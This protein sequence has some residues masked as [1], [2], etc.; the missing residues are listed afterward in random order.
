MSRPRYFNEYSCKMQEGVSSDTGRFLSWPKISGMFFGRG[1]LPHI[2]AHAQT[3]GN[4][5]IFFN[6]VGYCWPFTRRS[7]GQA[8]SGVIFI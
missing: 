1:V 5:G 8:V 2:V 4:R 7:V 6:P 3:C